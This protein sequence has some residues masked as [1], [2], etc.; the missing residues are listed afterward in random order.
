MSHPPSPSASSSKID[1]RE[2]ARLAPLELLEKSFSELTSD[3]LY[4][5]LALRQR[6]FVVEQNCAYLDCDG[7]DRDAIHLLGFRTGAL[8]AYARL[9]APGV[10]YREA[11]IGRILTAPEVRGTGL[12]RALVVEA[13]ARCESRFGTSAVRIGAQQRLERFYA[14][15]GFV[16]E[17]AP[18]DEDG[19]PHVEMR[20][21]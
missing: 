11:A 2:A 7:S 12:G 6:V 1:P 5:L 16:T 17:G 10:K 13:L 4:E 21:R 8:V 18:Y 14:E 15:L 20:R 3:E 9:F 19:I